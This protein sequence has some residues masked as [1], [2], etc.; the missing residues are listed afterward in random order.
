M[1]LEKAIIKYLAFNFI[2][3]N[4]ETLQLKSRIFKY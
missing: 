3:N 2:I 4:I 1:H